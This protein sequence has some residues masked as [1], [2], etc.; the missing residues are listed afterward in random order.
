MSDRI[1]IV[2]SPDDT[3][4]QGIRI[5]HVELTEEQ[6]SIVSKALLQCTLPHTLVNYTWKMGEPISWLLDKIPKCDLIIFNADTH[7]D[8]A[9]EIIIGWV[10][11]QHSSYYFGNLRDLHIAN[12]RVIFNDSDI[13]NLLETISKRYEQTT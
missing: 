1:L 10:A 6:N 3:L 5:L 2:T 7:P 4:L 12:D 13:N 11:A 8:G 9:T